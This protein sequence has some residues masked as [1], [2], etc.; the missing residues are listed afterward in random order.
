VPTYEE[1][2]PTSRFFASLT[3]YQNL[4]P[5]DA[6]RFQI[7]LAVKE[8]S[9]MEFVPEQFRGAGKTPAPATT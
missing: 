8:A 5:L 2:S 6:L 7:E 4:V 3:D 1:Y 9:D